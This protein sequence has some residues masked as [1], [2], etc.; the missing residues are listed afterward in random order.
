MAQNQ[1]TLTPSS[2]NRQARTLLESHFDMLWIEG[3][4][5][6]F[7]SPA[8]GHWYFSLKD[9]SAQVRCAM[10]KNRNTRLR[11][12]P[13]N[14]DQVR[15]RARVSLYEGRG[16]FQLIG[17]FLEPAGAG[18]L[19]AQFEALRDKLRDE[20]LFAEE[21]KRPLP[22]SIEH[23]AVVTSPTGAALQDVLEVLQRRNP[24][25]E[26]TVFAVPVQGEHAAEALETAV[27]EA[28]A[29]AKRDSA[30]AFDAILITRGGGSLEDLWAFNDE[31]LARAIATSA[32]PV[33][34]GVGHEVDVTIA[35]FAADVRAPTPSAAA[36]LLSEDRLELLAQLEVSERSLKRAIER[37]LERKQLELQSTSL[38]LK[39]PQDR[40]RQQLL[41]IDDLSQ[42]LARGMVAS[43]QSRKQKLGLLQQRLLG[44]SP[45]AEIVA[46][47]VALEALKAELNQAV[48]NR[49]RDARESVTK[50]KL[51]LESLSPLAVLNRGY[52]ILSGNDG[53]AVRTSG[54]V[55]TGQLLRARLASGS[56]ALRVESSEA[57]DSRDWEVNDRSKP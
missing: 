21:R 24:A 48:S 47:G 11:F 54:D 35:D 56:L 55:D 33:V 44:Q 20:G 37:L 38:R 27:L 28:N 2:L 9:D 25:V 57:M 6:N 43:L 40:I 8:S 30:P 12:R 18:A 29:L 22:R 15:L 4:L 17:E 45:E 1:L 7:A 34:S 13:K 41:R 14:G 16:E 39:H 23:L 46:A 10:F 49:L 42:R 26:V 31:A 5:S 3:E 36:E 32:L 50:Q 51:L 53:H 19:Q 52:A